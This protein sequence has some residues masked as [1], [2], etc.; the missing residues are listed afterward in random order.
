MIRK[1]AALGAACALVC[2]PSF[3]LA[4]TSPQ[5]P[6]PGGANQPPGMTAVVGIDAVT[7]APCLVGLT[8]ACRAP[9]I[10]A[11]NFTPIQVSLSPAAT[12][13]L[14]SRL[15]RQT[16]TLINTGSTAF[17]IGPTSSVTP[18]TGV[19][20]PAGVGVSITLAYCGALYGVTA[21]GTAAV[22]AYELY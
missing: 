12:Q 14:A 11:A 18:A 17:Y 19:L 15:G 7:G 5:F 16:L 2:A 3:S 4:Q 21:S 8:A 1:L 13:I 6:G 9:A 22:S 20:I 10:G